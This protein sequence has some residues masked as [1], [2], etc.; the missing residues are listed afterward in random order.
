MQ[1]GV[2]VC[3]CVQHSSSR[4]STAT[5]GARD[6]STGR[7]QQRTSSTSSAPAVRAVKA[8]LPPAA[9]STASARAASP[10]QP[11]ALPAHAQLPTPHSVAQPFVR[12]ALLRFP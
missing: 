7:R 10:S 11:C 12:V 8:R 1:A 4:A 3:V 9:A 5:P 2:C 6:V